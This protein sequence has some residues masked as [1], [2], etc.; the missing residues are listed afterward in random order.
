MLDG[1]EDQRIDA[2]YRLAQLAIQQ[3]L[4]QAPG[5]QC[6]KPGVE[7]NN[8]EVAGLPRSTVR[9]SVVY[10]LLQCASNHPL[11]DSVLA[12]LEV[13]LDDDDRYGSGFAKGLVDRIDA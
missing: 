6:L 1:R 5:L 7:A 10:A 4:V 2:T 3:P 11:P 8:T 13:L 12:A 9:E